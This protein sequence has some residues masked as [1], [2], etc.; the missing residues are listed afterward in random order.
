MSTHELFKKHFG[1]QVAV[2]LK[3][4]NMESFFKEL[5]EECLQENRVLKIFQQFCKDN[6]NLDIPDRIINKFE[7]YGDSSDTFRNV[8]DSL[9]IDFAVYLTGHD[10]ETIEQMYNDWRG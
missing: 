9:H 10:R 7:R 8:N 2:D 1:N 5:N 6:Y 3:H 4:P